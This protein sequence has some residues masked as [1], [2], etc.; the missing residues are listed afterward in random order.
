MRFEFLLGRDKLR[1]L[2]LF[3][4]VTIFL[5]INAVRSVRGS[6]V[7]GRMCF[8]SVFVICAEEQNSNQVVKRER[9][10]ETNTK[11]ARSYSQY[12]ENYLHR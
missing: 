8:L 6:S 10:R 9:E 5:S 3:R 12:T 2:Q 4:S 7:L 1:Q 11:N